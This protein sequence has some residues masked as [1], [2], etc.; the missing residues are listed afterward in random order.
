MGGRRSRVGSFFQGFNAGYDTTGRVIK[1]YE[2][3]KAATET[4]EESKAYTAD[5]SQQLEAAA[6]AKDEAGNPLY[7]VQANEGGTYSVTPTAGGETGTLE[8]VKQF[9]LDGKTQEQPFTREQVEAQQFRNQAGVHSRFGDAREAANLQGLARARDEEGVTSQIRAGAMDGLKSTADMRDEEKMFSMSK[10]M[11]EQAIKLNRPDLAT[12]YY[13]QMTQNRDALLARANERADRVFRATGNINGFVDAYNRYVADGLTIDAFKRNADGSHTFTMADGQ[14]SSREIMVPKEKTQEYLMALRDP[15]RIGE[16]EAKRADILF[17]SQADAQEAL[18]KP[19][20]VGKDQTLVVPSTGQ[21]FAPGDSRGFDPKDAGPVLD[22]TRKILLERSG[23]FD[24]ATGKWNWSPETQ[25]KAVVAERLLMK[26][27]Q[28]GPAQLADIADKGTTG[29]AVVEIGGKQQRVPAVS[30]NG[31]TYILGGSD[32]GMPASPP[33]AN[34][35][36]QQPANPSTTGLGTRS[37]SGKIGGLSRAE[38]AKDFPRVSVNDQAAKDTEAGKIL[39]A[40]AGSIEQAKKD[41]AELDAAIANPRLD[42]TQR[43]ILQSHRN[44]LAAGIA[45]SS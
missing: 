6:N 29:T 20:A 28:L 14:G 16:L 32:T 40:E 2:L 43:G 44:R 38:T 34:G 3:N 41:L 9:T 4:P 36:G 31:R 12:G 37:V 33:R 35:V 25:A 5:Q 21:T 15:K 30:H 24:M 10:G 18:N 42:G 39:V 23:N 13:N 17:K 1:D 27:P 19:V 26:N 8:P 22:D 45:A 11:Y 7:N